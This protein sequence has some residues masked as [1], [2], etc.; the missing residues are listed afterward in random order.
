LLSRQ[1][2][3]QHRAAGIALDQRSRRRFGLLHPVALAT[4]PTRRSDPLPHR[5][6]PRTQVVGARRRSKIAGQ[7]VDGQ[8]VSPLHHL[9]GKALDYRFR[10][11]HECLPVIKTEDRCAR[12]HKPARDDGYDN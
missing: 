2:K 9:A 7:V 3:L 5:I 6:E 1:P 10:W 12:E 4:H 8:F 11:R